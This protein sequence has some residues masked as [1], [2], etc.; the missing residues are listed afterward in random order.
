[1]SDVN[2]LAQNALQA[3]ASARGIY[4]V[5]DPIASI[6]ECVSLAEGCIE[7]G[8]DAG[9]LIYLRAA[10]R[11]NGTYLP[12]GDLRERAPEL[13]ARIREAHDSILRNALGMDA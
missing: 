11:I 2:T 12:V 7:R 3:H 5:F 6:G 10:H 4:Q 9:A 1:M 8:N 13:Y